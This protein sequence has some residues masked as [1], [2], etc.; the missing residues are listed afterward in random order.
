MIVPGNR[1]L[2]WVAAIVL[3]F[4]AA[5]A[6]IPSIQSP[7]LGVIALFFVL[8]LIDAT[9]AWR[10]LDAFDVEYPP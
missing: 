3:P 9:W 7:A 4:A 5:G 8:V 1:L 10:S 2:F 6:L